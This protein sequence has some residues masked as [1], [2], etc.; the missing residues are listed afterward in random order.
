MLCLS[1]KNNLSFW[2]EYLTKEETITELAIDDDYDK[3]YNAVVR[4]N[5]YCYGNSIRNI[6]KLENTSLILNALV[7]C[8]KEWERKHFEQS[9]QISA[10]KETLGHYYC[11]PYCEFNGIDKDKGKNSFERHCENTF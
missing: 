11:R 9:N 4:Y 10:I 5:D 2:L 7:Q 8:H 1:E 3:E 6:L